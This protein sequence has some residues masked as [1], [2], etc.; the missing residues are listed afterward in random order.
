MTQA[1]FVRSGDGDAAE[2]KTKEEEKEQVF[3][4]A[5]SF[6]CS[7]ADIT[8]A[9]TAAVDDDSVMVLSVMLFTA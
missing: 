7:D 2:I 4:F 1:V 9:T 3:R 6:C 5:F 8:G